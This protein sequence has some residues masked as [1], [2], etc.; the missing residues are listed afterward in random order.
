M[1]TPT[2]S[3]RRKG[4][5]R[6]A[7]IP[8]DV[9]AALNRGEI[10][11]VTLVEWLVID[12]P[13]LLRHALAS[14]GVDAPNAVARA[15]AVA[16]ER[17]TLSQCEVGKALHDEV[18]EALEALACHRSDTVRAWA[19]FM[20]AADESLDLADRLERTKR[21]AADP[22]LAE[23]WRTDSPT[24]ETGWTLNHALRTLRKRGVAA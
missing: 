3:P 8:P 23:R 18:P 24:A 5:V 17:F 10:E 19:A 12:M 7:D 2:E 21:F 14:A 16:G 9:M 1:S 15:E 4:A 22:N 11:S 6:M 13:Q 20:L